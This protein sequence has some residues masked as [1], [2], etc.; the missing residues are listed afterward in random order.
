M[1]VVGFLLVSIMHFVA[2]FHMCRA[3]VFMDS[4][5]CYEYFCVK[6]YNSMVALFFAI[7]LLM[8]LCFFSVKSH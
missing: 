4:F 8:A 2:C 7:V 5:D 3:K 1:S 6:I